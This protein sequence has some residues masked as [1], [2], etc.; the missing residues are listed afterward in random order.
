MGEGMVL[1]E[2]SVAGG[3]S[4]AE[5]SS[6]GKETARAGKESLRSKG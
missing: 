4:G 3:P 2:T 6:R 5:R 1:L